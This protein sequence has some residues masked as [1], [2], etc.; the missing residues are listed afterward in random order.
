M[1]DLGWA[2]WEPSDFCCNQHRT[3]LC[4]LGLAQSNT[5]KVAPISRDIDAPVGGG[6]GGGEGTGLIMHSSCI[7][8]TTTLQVKYC[9]CLIL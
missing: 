8:L 4:R 5:K 2:G 6:G 7:L 1:A 3:H 9:Q